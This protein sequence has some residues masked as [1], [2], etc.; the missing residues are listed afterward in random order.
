M[1]VADVPIVYGDTA[2]VRVVDMTGS[3]RSNAPKSAVNDKMA[4]DF[5]D[6]VH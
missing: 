6:G 2:F 5:F 4:D 1:R 3:K